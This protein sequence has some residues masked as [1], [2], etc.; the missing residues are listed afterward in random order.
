LANSKEKEDNFLAI[1]DL[2]RQI[3]FKL[4]MNEHVKFK[5]GTDELQSLVLKTG[6]ESLGSR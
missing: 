5:N 3:D 4:L 6:V 1:K 2:H